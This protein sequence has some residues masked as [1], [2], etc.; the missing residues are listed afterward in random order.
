MAGMRRRIAAAS[1]R[2]RVE[3]HI[4]LARQPLAV[5]VASVAFAGDGPPRRQ[6][7]VGGRWKSP[8]RPMVDAA[9]RRRWRDYATSSGR[10]PVRDFVEALSDS[11]AAAVLAGMEEVRDRGVR[12][13]RHLDGDIWEVRVE[14]KAKKSSATSAFFLHNRRRFSWFALGQAKNGG[15]GSRL[16]TAQRRSVPGC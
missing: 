3:G 7:L 11:D 14:H 5:C 9:D 1:R 13:A 8:G 2:R 16:G 10:R 12:A 6:F 4:V 15:C